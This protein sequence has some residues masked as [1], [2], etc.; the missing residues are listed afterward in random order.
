MI[1]IQPLTP[2]GL[3]L[4][5]TRSPV[6][7]SVPAAQLVFTATAYEGVSGVRIL[8]NGEEVSIPTNDEDLEP[9][10]ILFKENYERFNPA[11]PDVIPTTTTEQSG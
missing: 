4:P 10:A 11:N 3:R 2:E 7:S 6:I 5:R 9:G 8:I 1:D